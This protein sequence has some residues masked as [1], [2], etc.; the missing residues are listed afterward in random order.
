MVASVANLL[1]IPGAV[2]VRAAALVR[3]GVPAPTAGEVNILAVGTWAGVAGAFSGIGILLSPAQPTWVGATVTAASIGLVLAFAV[4]AR[5]R[6]G[7][8]TA[9]WLVLVETATVV[10][11]GLRIFLAAHVLDSDLAFSEAMLLGA[12]QVV[13]ALIGFVPGGLG[14]RELVTALLGSIVD[15][16]ADVAVSATAVDRVAAQVGTGLIWLLSMVV[17]GSGL[18]QAWRDVWQRPAKG[19]G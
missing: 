18:K 13:T 9:F 14:V 8:V 12:G 15:V 5:S 4:R 17:F 6:G 7:S 19:E 11:S 1:P 2:A 3:R 10:I 16:P